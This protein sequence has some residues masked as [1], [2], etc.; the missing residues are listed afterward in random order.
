MLSKYYSQ[1]WQK[2]KD[3]DNLPCSPCWTTVKKGFPTF[4]EGVCWSVGRTSNLKFWEDKWVKGDFLREMMVGPLRVWEHN[5]TIMEV[6]QEGNW[7]WDIISYELPREIKEKICVIPM[8]LW[9]NKKDI[10]MWKFTRDGEFSTALAYA[11]LRPKED[12]SQTF[13]GKNGFGSLTFGPRSSFSF[14][15]VTM[16]VCL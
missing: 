5:L 6:F 1:S 14:G 16:I 10:L 3:P 8:Q 15:C 4:T 11:L 7:N 12:E 9:G 2:S 13:I